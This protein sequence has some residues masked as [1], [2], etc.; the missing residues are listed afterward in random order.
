[1]S[2]SKIRIGILGAGSMGSEHAGCYREMSDVE[3]VGV[4][5]RN[6][7]HASAA[8][9]ICG[10]NATTDPM[11]LIDDSSVDAI[12][13]CVPSVNHRQF[14]IA[15]LNKGK[16]VFC[17]TPFAL[18]LDDGRAMIEAARQSKR[19]LMVGLLMRSIAY[20]EHIHRAAISGEHGKLLSMT[21]HRLG[22]YLRPGAPDHKAHYSDPSTELM[23]FDFDFVLWLMG[24]PLRIS[25]TAVNERDAPGEISA[26]LDYDGARSA[27][28]L[29]SGIMPNSFPFWVGFRAV[30]ERG[31]F[32][33]ENVFEAGPP[34]TSFTFFP[35]AGPPQAVSLQGANPYE[36]E[37]RLFAQTIRG[38]TD[39][40]LLDPENAMKALQLSIAT[41][42]SLREHRAIEL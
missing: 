24:P 21:T 35:P 42:R 40:R 31:A 10:A 2:E 14:V 18:S 11:A 38:E 6:S 37:L 8:A 30:F 9:K 41:Q 5:S 25:A 13:V 23:T 22:S 20:Y 28:V 17:E 1:M 19:I 4:F 33:L 39:G 12:D 29:A 27:T 36:K 15:A 32:E 16:H 3:V 34:K 7:E 26:V